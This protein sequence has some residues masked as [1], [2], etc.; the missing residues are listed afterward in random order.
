M[1]NFVNFVIQNPPLTIPEFC[2]IILYYLIIGSKKERK[3]ERKG[4]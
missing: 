3:K 4:V 2:I 1:N